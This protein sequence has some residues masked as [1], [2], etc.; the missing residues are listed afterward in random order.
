M[1]TPSISWGQSSVA[2][3]GG[4]WF[5]AQQMKSYFS[6]KRRIRSSTTLTPLL[7][8]HRAQMKPE[9]VREAEL[10]LKLSGPEVAQA[11][12]RQGE[13]MGRLRKFQESYE[14]ICCAVNQVPP[15]DA[16][17][18]WPKEIAGVKMEH[19]IAWMRSA[20]WISGTQHPAISVPA[21]FTSTGLPVGLQIVGRYRSDFEVLRF[22]HMFEEA[23]RV[24][25]T[26]PKLIG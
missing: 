19:Y 6:S 25:Q 22:A 21:G 23:T 7:E 3:N 4:T 1:L 24:G 13:I 8:K 5:T 16:T 18:D 17:L 15:F 26:R 11:M 10:G 12:V 14:F 2:S 20:S 9:A